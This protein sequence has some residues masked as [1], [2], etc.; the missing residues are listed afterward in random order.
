MVGMEHTYPRTRRQAPHQ[1]GEIR[2]QMCVLPCLRR[3]KAVGP[4]GV[5]SIL[6][7]KA[8]RREQR[9]FHQKPPCPWRGAKREGVASG[10]RAMRRSV[11]QDDAAGLAA[12]HLSKE[13]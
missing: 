12:L 13:M 9:A 8:I 5:T 10:A 1:H 3:A 11:R 7:A 6:P 2:I 4:C